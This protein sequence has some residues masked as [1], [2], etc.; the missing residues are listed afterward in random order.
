MSEQCIPLLCK[1]CSSTQMTSHLPETTTGSGCIQMH[2]K[3]QDSLLGVPSRHK[4]LP[5]GRT[6][7]PT[8]M[9]SVLPC[10][11]AYVASCKAAWGGPLQP[12]AAEC[13]RRLPSSR[14]LYSAWHGSPMP[15][16]QAPSLPGWTGL[17]SR[18]TI[19][20]PAVFIPAVLKHKSFACPLAHS[21][22]LTVLAGIDY[23]HCTSSMPGA[24]DQACRMCSV[25]RQCKVCS[26]LVMLW[27]QGEMQL[28]D[29][30]HSLIF[31]EELCSMLCMAWHVSHR[32][33][34]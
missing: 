22:I 4:P 20:Q 28:A 17:Q 8:G 26:V 7:W 30:V 27:V 29:W 19:G 33:M 13:M 21:I 12:G 6:W 1:W 24:N 3:L 34:C 25:G 32:H 16:L 9:P 18:R 10:Q 2:F 11:T 5:A 31:C 14:R 23:L 15:I